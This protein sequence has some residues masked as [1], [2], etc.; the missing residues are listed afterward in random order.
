MAFGQVAPDIG[1]L[2]R[3]VAVDHDGLRRNA[4]SPGTQV[5]RALAALIASRVM[6]MAL[7][8]GLVALLF[9]HLP[10]SELGVWLLMGQAAS[11]V[12]LMDFGVT[13]VLTRRLAM[14]AGQPDGVARQAADLV[15]SARV[16]YHVMAVLVGVA[17]IIASWRLLEGASTAALIAW[18]LLSLGN[19]YGLY[20]GLTTAMVTGFG[21]VAEMSVRNTC[22][23]VVV[24]A[25]QAVAVLWGGGLVALAALSLAGSLGLGL[26][27]QSL[28][29][30]REA[31]LLAE[32]GRRDWSALRG[33]LA[34][35]GRYWL[36]E[37][38]AI[39]LLRTDQLFIAGFQG[40]ADIPAYYA[41]YS[42]VF[43][44]AT[45][46]MAIS[47]AACVFVSRMWQQQAPE[48]VHALVLRSTRLGLSMML[49]GAGLMAVIG[50]S[51][52]AVWIGPG[53]FVGRPVM[54]VF[55]AMLVL[56]VQQSLLLGFSRAT[57]NERYA[58]CFLLAGGLNLLITWWLA[59]PL[60][61]LGIAAGTLIAQALTVSWYVPLSALHR[62]QIPLRTYAGAVLWPAVLTGVATSAAAFLATYDIAL[63][64]PAYRMAAGCGGGFLA[65]LLCAWF[66]VIDADMR[67]VALRAVR[68]VL[69]PVA[70]KAG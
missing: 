25:G 9:R 1:S 34:S 69:R 14:S 13:S 23:G 45:L 46:S 67:G 35:S 19:I 21:H 66:L 39:A 56:F 54:L 59:A 33:L 20:R 58:P 10:Q 12:A 47:E 70:I 18:A 48:A 61:L 51:I 26:A 17:L 60:G 65:A 68:Q 28:L 8:L 16:L 30:R 52:I 53:H 24:T 43:T 41:A 32:A 6:A 37:L 55:C 42:I 11:L 5:A 57:E 62:L 7:N 31:G 44:M 36:T 22:I 49:A 15:A 2:D 50:D 3:G 4:M 40:A 27:L 29:R 64:L 38:G 63:S